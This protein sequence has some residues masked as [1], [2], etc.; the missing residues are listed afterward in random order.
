[1]SSDIE[2]LEAWLGDTNTY[3]IQFLANSVAYN[4]TGKTVSW[5]ISEGREDAEPLVQRDVTEHDD[6]VNGESHVDFTPE[7]IEEAGVGDRWLHVLLIDAGGEERTRV[8]A[9]LRV[10]GRPL[11]TEEEP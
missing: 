8:V 9:K 6:A 5:L 4:I 7:E 1:M 11:R 3:S 2:E 10:W